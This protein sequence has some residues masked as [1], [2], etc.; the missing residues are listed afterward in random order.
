MFENHVLVGVVEVVIVGMFAIQEHAEVTRG[1]EPGYAEAKEGHSWPK[2]LR[3]TRSRRRRLHHQKYEHGARADS[4]RHCIL[5]R[6]K[7]TD[8]TS[9]TV[10]I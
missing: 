10:C 6:R 1:A 8:R 4:C 7:E 5:Q 2:E 3:L 9:L